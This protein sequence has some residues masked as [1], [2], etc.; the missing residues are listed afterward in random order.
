MSVDFGNL[1]N[2]QSS[3]RTRPSVVPVADYPAI[4]TKYEPV[5][6]NKHFEKPVWQIRVFARLQGLPE[7]MSQ[8]DVGVADVRGIVLKKEFDYQNEDGSDADGLWKLNA[9][10]ESV[11]VAP[12]SGTYGEL[13]PQLQG[14]QVIASVGQWTDKKT[15]DVGGNDIKKMVGIGG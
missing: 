12:G 4:I 5:P 8:E 9:L 2:K 1:L 15:G 3:D 7:G 6:P 11:G 10:L 14:K 13:L